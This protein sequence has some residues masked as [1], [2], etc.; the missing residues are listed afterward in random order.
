MSDRWH[1]SYRNAWKNGLFLG[2]MHGR[3]ADFTEECM[4]EMQISWKNA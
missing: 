3:I 4:T 1:I 2:R